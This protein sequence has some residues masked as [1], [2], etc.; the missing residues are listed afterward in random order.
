MADVS[1]TTAAAAYAKGL[2]DAAS[3][4]AAAPGSESFSDYVSDALAA[5][6]ETGLEAERAT[7]RA[8]A[9]E[10]SLQE[11]VTSITNA[12][13]TLQTVVALRDRVISAYNDIMRMPI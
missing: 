3:A 12:E 2:A 4:R 9:G 10:V 13:V 6:R 8:L 1:F 7:T 11:V 5:A